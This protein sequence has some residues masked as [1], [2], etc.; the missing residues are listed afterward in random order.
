M[1]SSLCE[2]C[3]AAHRKMGD[4]F[5]PACKKIVIQQLRDRTYTEPVRKCTEAGSRRGRGSRLLGGTPAFD[6]Y[7]TEG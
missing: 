7:N 6:D 2:K 3:G 4:R 5:C 1:K